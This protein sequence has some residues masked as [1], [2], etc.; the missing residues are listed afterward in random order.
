MNP[1]G[2]FIDSIEWG[3]NYSSIPGEPARNV[4]EGF[5]LARIDE[6]N[7]S[8]TDFQQAIPTPGSR[9]IPTSSVLTIPM[10]PRYIPKILQNSMYSN[11]FSIYIKLSNLP[12]SKNYSLKVYIAKDKHTSPGSQTWNGEEWLYSNYYA[13]NITTDEYGNWS[14]WVSL[15][16][17]RRYNGYQ[18][19]LENNDSAVLG[20]KLRGDN[21]FIVE[22]EK[23]VYLLDMDDST[24]N[25]Y[26]GG[27]LIG[28]LPGNMTNG[29]V[30]ILD[31]NDTITGCYHCENNSIDEG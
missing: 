7:N 27:Y 9:N 30:M 17:C 23:E 2:S 3:I 12:P 20:V 15:R 10:Y 19:Y 8:L 6:N 5:S 13:L 31:E 21:D 4:D 16:L 1:N 11:P 25:G 28:V 22:V 24:S 29:V 18:T 26:P 14:I